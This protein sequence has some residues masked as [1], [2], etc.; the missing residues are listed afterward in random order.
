MFGI[1]LSTNNIDMQAAFRRAQQRTISIYMRANV[2]IFNQHLIYLE[3]IV[4]PGIF[5]ITFN[6]GLSVVY[7]GE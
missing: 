3:A 2:T 6:S 7:F 5:Q 1:C 4:R